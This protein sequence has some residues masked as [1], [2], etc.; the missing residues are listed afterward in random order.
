MITGKE[1]RLFWETLVPFSVGIMEDDADI[2]NMEDKENWRYK[3]K[4]K[5]KLS[6]P[7]TKSNGPSEEWTAVF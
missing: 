7:K 1:E 2:W 4:L 5:L 3:K 6:K